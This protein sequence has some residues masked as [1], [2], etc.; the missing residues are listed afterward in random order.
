LKQV[1]EEEKQT[2]IRP[3][4]RNARLLVEEEAFIVKVIVKNKY[5]YL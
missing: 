2:V 5:K 3:Y 4:I 1:W